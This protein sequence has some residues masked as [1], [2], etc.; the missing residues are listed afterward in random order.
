LSNFFDDDVQ[1]REDVRKGV[2][3]ENLT[4]VE[5]NSV[6]D[7]IQLLSQV[8][9]I[10]SFPV[11]ATRRE[12]WWRLFGFSFFESEKS[13]ADEDPP[14]CVTGIGQQESGSHQYEQRVEPV[15]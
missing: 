11:T 6:Q 14:L 4:E 8:T 15:S 10:S 9:S 3:V 13:R 7:V 5:V 2:Y 12:H 1:M